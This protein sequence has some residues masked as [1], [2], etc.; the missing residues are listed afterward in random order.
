[1]DRRAFVTGL[2][3]ILTAQRGAEAQQ[4]AKNVRIGVLAPGF[5]H[6]APDLRLMKALRDLGWVEGRNVVFEFRFD[7]GKRDRL[8]ALA[9]ELAGRNV[10]VIFTRGTPA[11]LAAQ[12]ATRTIPIVMIIVVEPVRSGLVT[13]LARPGG[14]VT[15]MASLG[16]DIFGK[17]LE[18]LKQIVPGAFTVAVLFDPLNPAQTDQLH[19]EL[20]A[21]AAILAVKLHPLRVDAPSALEAVFAEAV[22]KRSD[23]LLVYPLGTSARIGREVADLAI[24][25]RLP[26]VTTFR[27]YAEQ[28]VLA[29]FSPSIDEQYE[30]AAV[31]INKILRGARPADLP[32][33][34]PS[35]FEL[36]VNL[37]TAKALGLTIPPSLLLRADQVIE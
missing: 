28:G 23:A 1:M 10:D 14:N 25:H 16:A 5:P 29:S 21:A 12:A 22:R 11:A 33:E 26:A 6:S 24:K 19:N 13:S 7:E 3:V 2:A 30:R 37:K 32:V 35:K 34:Q 18:V 9:T 36:V 31:Y 4:P 15:G 27:V 17:Q 20:A 8:S